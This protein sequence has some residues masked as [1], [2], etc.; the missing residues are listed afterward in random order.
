MNSLVLYL[1]KGGGR[2]LAFRLG[3]GNHMRIAEG[4]DMLALN[5]GP[6]TIHPTILFDKE[7]WVLIDTGMPGSAPAIRELAKQAGALNVPLRAII[8][9]HQDIDHVGGLP[10]FLAAE[11]ESPIVYAHED[12]K[13]VINGAKPMIK[14]SPERLT[15]LLGQLPEVTVTNS[16]R[17]SYIRRTPTWSVRLR[18]ERSCRSRAD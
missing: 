6:M 16:S 11:D 10:E 3:I 15:A 18:T 2:V 8:L 9:T 7:S 4:I 13:D 1:D 5:L 17:L 14:V 12:D